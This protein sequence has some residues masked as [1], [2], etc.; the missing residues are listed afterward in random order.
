MLLTY[1]NDRRVSRYRRAI[2]VLLTWRAIVVPLTLEGDHIASD[3]DGRSLCFLYDLQSQW[4]G[5]MLAIIGFLTYVTII[6]QLTQDGDLWLLASPD[7]NCS[8]EIG[9]RS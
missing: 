4:F 6:A 1:A 5:I 7:I 8:S 9:G 2:I 3:R